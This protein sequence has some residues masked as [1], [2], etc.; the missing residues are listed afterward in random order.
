MYHLHCWSYAFPFFFIFGSVILTKPGRTERKLHIPLGH[1]YNLIQ[2]FLVTCLRT[3]RDGWREFPSTERKVLAHLF[4]LQSMWD[5]QLLLISLYFAHAYKAT[6]ARNTIKPKF[7]L[8]FD[9]LYKKILHIKSLILRCQDSFNRYA[10][11]AFGS[12]N[13]SYLQLERNLLQRL[14]TS[15]VVGGSLT[16]VECVQ[17]SAKAVV[18]TAAVLCHQIRGSYKQPCFFHGALA[19]GRCSSSACV[20]LQ[21]LLLVEVSCVFG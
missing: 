20:L 3:R 17:T 16:L 21:Q 12:F 4:Y 2:D 1:K 11:Q 18:P 7:A 5:F 9:Y 6:E 15:Q 19:R 10:K 13:L 14:P 8:F